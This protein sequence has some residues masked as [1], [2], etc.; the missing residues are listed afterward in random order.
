MADAPHPI[1]ALANREGLD[2][3]A[4]LAAAAAGWSQ[5]GLRV[6]GLLARNADTGEVCSADTL[7]DIAS[8]RPYSVRL[9]EAPALTSCHLDVAGME[10]ACAAVLGQID[11]ADVV[12]LSK[13]GKL[14]AMGRGLWPAFVATAAAGKPLLTSVSDKHLAAWTAFAPTG[15]W[16]DADPAAIAGWWQALAPGHRAQA[17]V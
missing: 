8:D 9:D 6:A 11:A 5:A 14:E 4:L 12:V 16:L 15:L 2:S 10:T 3:Q 1:A 7:T 13:F 17:T